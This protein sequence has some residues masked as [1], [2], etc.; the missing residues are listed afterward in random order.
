[1]RLRAACE[2]SL[3]NKKRR[4]MK[5]N[6][7]K[8]FEEQLEEMNRR[9]DT[10]WFLIILSLFV[11]P[12][13]LVGLDS[14]SS[15]VVGSMI[16]DTIVNVLLYVAIGLSVFVIGAFLLKVIQSVKSSLLDGED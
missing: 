13:A 5:N 8:S 3:S 4:K 11:I 15:S 6:R 2:V 10:G 9:H 12:M 7:E 1:M 16:T 14:L